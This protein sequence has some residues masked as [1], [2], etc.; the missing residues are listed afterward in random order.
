MNRISVEG[1]K[2]GSRFTHPV[3]FFFCV[4][5]FVAE[6]IPVSQRDLDMIKTW[7]ITS[8]F[9]CGRQLKDGE[10]FTPAKDLSGGRKYEPLDFIIDT[11][12]NKN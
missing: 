11:S 4:N 8:L 5:M 12:A 6:N 7:K 2:V 10:Q 1:I 9:T 3:F